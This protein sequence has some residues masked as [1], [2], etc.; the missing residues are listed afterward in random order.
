MRLNTA[1][2]GAARL[3]LPAGERGDLLRPDVPAPADR[4]CHMTEDPKTTL[5][6]YP[7]V[8]SGG[9]TLWRYVA[10]VA[11]ADVR[12]PGHFAEMRHSLRVG[13]LMLVLA[14]DGS[15]MVPVR[16][17]CAIGAGV[18]LSQEAATHG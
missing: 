10:S 8:Q 7:I 3:Y 5:E 2:A 15:A 4:V 1:D 14:T 11:L 17:G 6:L 12:A 9:F 18:I 13:D 16:Q